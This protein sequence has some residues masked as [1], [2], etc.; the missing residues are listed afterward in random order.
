MQVIQ[1]SL[2][3]PHGTLVPTLHFSLQGNDYDRAV[4]KDWLPCCQLKEAISIYTKPHCIKSNLC[5]VL[6][7]CFFFLKLCWDYFR[8]YCIFHVSCLGMTRNCT[9][10]FQKELQ[11]RSNR[12]HAVLGM[13]FVD[14]QSQD[15]FSNLLKVLFPR[16]YRFSIIFLTISNT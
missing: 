15:L 4:Q 13:K 8:L 1:L 14:S 6:K 12:P 5:W 7:L 10:N 3:L 11:Q 16:S 9:A 2:T